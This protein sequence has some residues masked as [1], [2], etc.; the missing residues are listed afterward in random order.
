MIKL[1]HSKLSAVNILN[2]PS[3]YLSLSNKTTPLCLSDFFPKFIVLKSHFP[4][5]IT[6]N[7]EKIL[8]SNG[9]F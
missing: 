3:I 4:M 5:V 8:V 2:I 6:K 9:Q 1:K 7:K